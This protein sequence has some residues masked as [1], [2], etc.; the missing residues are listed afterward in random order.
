MFSAS[1]AMLPINVPGCPGIG[2]KTAMKLIS[3][4]AVL[5][6]YIKISTSLKVK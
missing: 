4:Y 5:K 3:E 6:G 2:P 1:W